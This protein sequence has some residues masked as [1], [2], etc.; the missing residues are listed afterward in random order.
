MVASSAMLDADWPLTQ[1]A[2]YSDRHWTPS[3]WPTL[4]QL[5]GQQEPQGPNLHPLHLQAFKTVSRKKQGTRWRCRKVEAIICL[6]LPSV[7][8]TILETLH[9]V[10]Q[11]SPEASLQL[12]HVLWQ[13]VPCQDMAERRQIEVSAEVL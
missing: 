6:F 7:L 4:A 2:G 5:P 11:G 13:M 10:C 3:S 8:Q 9:L 12:S 1:R